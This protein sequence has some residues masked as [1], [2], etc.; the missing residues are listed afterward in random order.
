ME[1]IADF[2]TV[3]T[4]SALADLR[5]TGIYS[6]WF[7]R[8]TGMAASQLAL[9][10]DGVALAFAL[11]GTRAQRGAAKRFPQAPASRPWKAAS[12]QRLA[13]GGRL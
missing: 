4:F 10:L 6:A 12:S 11:L 3:A 1:T 8:A 9:C 7:S 13:C 5:A 2:G